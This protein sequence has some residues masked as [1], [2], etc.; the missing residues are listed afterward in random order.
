MRSEVAQSS[1]ISTRTAVARR[2]RASRLGKT[3]T[4]LVRRLIS[5]WIARSHRADRMY[6]VVAGMSAVVDPAAT[7]HDRVAPADLS[8][9]AVI[10]IR[11]AAVIGICPCGGGSDELRNAEENRDHKIEHV[12]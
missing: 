6:F 5:C 12:A 1:S 8:A 9:S 7:H 3:R 10:G 2:S 4:L 11:Q